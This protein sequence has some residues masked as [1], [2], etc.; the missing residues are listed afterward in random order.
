MRMEIICLTCSKTFKVSPYRLKRSDA[1]VKFCSYDC[2]HKDLKG[3]VNE[4]LQSARKKWHSENKEQHSMNM[5]NRNLSNE[6]NPSWKGERV[7]YGQLH[8]WIGI[9]KGKAEICSQCGS[10][11]TVCWANID[12]EYS[13]NLED[14]I[15]LCITCH[16]KHDKP[17]F[18]LRKLLFERRKIA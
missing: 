6:M 5:R 13:R 2:Y 17:F 7:S 16:M 15:E 1:S 9:K 14:Y 4:K 12:N 8:R 3:H 11:N 18:G 10:N